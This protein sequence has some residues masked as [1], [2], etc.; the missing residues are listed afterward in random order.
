[1]TFN[2]KDLTPSELK[3]IEEHRYFLGIELKREVSIDEAIQSFFN[4]YMED[5][6]REKTRR[7]NLEQLQEIQKHKYLKSKEAGRDLGEEAID[8]W[9]KK[10][11]E[12]WRQE[13][14][15][16]IA[17][18]F[19]SR[20]ITIK[21]KNGLH[22]RPSGTLVEIAKKYDCSIY[23]HKDG[24][25]HY[26]FKLN[27]IPFMNVSSVLSLVGLCASMGDEI[28]FIAYG[29]QAKDALDA[30]EALLTKENF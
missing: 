20:K 9:M 10:Y 5:W 2:N 22:V 6:R 18:G 26:N 16:L 30:I 13:K 1:M 28:T 12:I 29:K 7:D 25:E 27:G 24:M 11:A 21:N 4:K 3:A 23:I 19:L 17:N 15:S 14:E 8:E